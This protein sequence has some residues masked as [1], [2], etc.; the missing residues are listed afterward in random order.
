MK[1]LNFHAVLLLSIVMLF[2]FSCNKESDKQES[3]KEPKQEQKTST[4]KDTVQPKTENTAAGKDVTLSASEQKKL[5]I[6]FSNFSEVNLK[7]FNRGEISTDELINF[8]V[9]HNYINNRKLFEKSSE[10]KV[11][12]SEEYVINSVQK[13]FGLELEKQ[14]STPEITYKTGNYYIPESSGEA[15]YFS[16]V[17]KVNDIG[18]D[19]FIAYIN[20][21]SASS[22]WTGNAHA[23][24]KDWDANADDKPQLMEKFKASYLKSMKTNGEPAYTLVDYI[25]Q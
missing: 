6:F 13:Y 20:V 7:P 4:A 18:Y 21:Y 8:G 17:E 16:Q 5:N 12:I 9:Y 2:M 10:G 15:F 24:P 22:G 1:R 19:Q 25:K 11:R 23:N 3:K 14:E